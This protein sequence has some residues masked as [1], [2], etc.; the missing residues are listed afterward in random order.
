MSITLSNV[1]NNQ[2]HVRCFCPMFLAGPHCFAY[3]CSRAFLPGKSFSMYIVVRVTGISHCRLVDE[4]VSLG[5]VN[6][7]ATRN[8]RH[9]NDNVH[10]KGLARKK[11][12][13][14]RVRFAKPENYCLSKA[15]MMRFRQY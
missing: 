11:R 9:A 5:D 15:N 10:A 13:T 6:K 14:S 2:F 8:T 7:P 3:P 1:S 4:R 12:S